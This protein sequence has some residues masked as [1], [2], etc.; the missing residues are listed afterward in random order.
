LRIDLNKI[1]DP[2]SQRRLS[3]GFR[4][5]E[6]AGPFLESDAVHIARGETL[7]STAFAAQH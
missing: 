3:R 5:P 4:E 2:G 1:T 7:L 6:I